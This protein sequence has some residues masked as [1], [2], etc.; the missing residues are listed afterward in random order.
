MRVVTTLRLEGNVV[1]ARQVGTSV[2]IVI[3]TPFDVLPVDRRAVDVASAQLP[4]PTQAQRNRAAVRRARITDWLP[5]Y[6]LKRSGEPVRRGVVT[7]CKRVNAPVRFGGFGTVSVVTLDASN[8]LRI[9]DSDTIVSGSDVVYASP[10]SLYVATSDWYDIGVW[11]ERRIPPP[12][13]TRI[14][15]FDISDPVQTVY[16]ASGSVPGFVPGQWAMSERAGLLRVASTQEPAWW[17]GNEA[18]QSESHVSVLGEQDGRLLTVGHVA[19]IGRGERI[20]GVRFIGDVGYVVTF[21][22]VDPLHIVDVATPSAPKLRGELQIPGFSAYLHPVGDGLLLGVGQDADA[23]GQTLGTQVSLFDVSNLDAPARIASLRL[24]EGTFS[25]AEWDH[26]AFTYWTPTGLAVIPFTDG[27]ATGVPVATPVAGAASSAKAA[28]FRVAGR[29]L[30][31]AGRI[32]HPFVR[33]DGDVSASPIRRSVVVGPV[34]YSVSE[35]GIRASDL[36]T[37]APTGW[38]AFPV[39]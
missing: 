25:E 20:T 11:Q 27:L 15:R 5:R 17:Q 31:D 2:R 29:T 7:G 9:A 38:M 33:V 35:D 26:K 30:T 34:V 8:G 37:L 28:G 36:T 39:D 32:V 4:G 3:S 10:T 18:R 13:S 6:R 23:R 16:R 24:T 19:G 1:A 12:G 21:R 22:Q 14:H